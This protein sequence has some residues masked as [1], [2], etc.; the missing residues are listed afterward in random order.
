MDLNKAEDLFPNIVIKKLGGGDEN[1]G[2]AEFKTLFDAVKQ[3][4]ALGGK[5]KRQTKKRRKAHRK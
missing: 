4:T 1:K 5:K 3:P 2:K